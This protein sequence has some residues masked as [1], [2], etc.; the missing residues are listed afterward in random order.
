MTKAKGFTLIE[1][2]VVVAII[3]LLVAILIPAVQRAREEANRAICGTNLHGIDQ[4]A[5][6]YSQANHN[7]Y[8][9]GWP[10]DEDLPDRPGEWTLFNSGD[11]VD[12]DI[13]TPQ[14]S[15]AQLV[16]DGLLPCGS[17]IC[18]TVGGSPAEDEWVLVGIGGDF[19]GD[20]SAAA[21]RYSHYAYQDPG[22]YGEDGNYKASTGTEGGWPVFGD[23]GKRTD[24]D[25]DDYEYDSYASANHDMKPGCQMIL[26]GA[27]GVKK[28]YTETSNNPDTAYDETNRCMV[29]YSNAQLYDNIYTDDDQSADANDTWL[30]SS[31]GNA[32]PVTPPPP[33]PPP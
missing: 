31:D 22:G 5:Y 32:G 12:D 19:D 11:A 20:R 16:H 24:P 4:A 26:G 6:L 8:P 21:E 15:F 10:H 29:G 2:L 30:L 33:P 7:K 18:P 9:F 13:I 27:H 28:E 3:A 25:N 1:L 14:D 23:R 17:L